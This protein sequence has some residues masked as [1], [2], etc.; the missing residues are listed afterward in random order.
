MKQRLNSRLLEPETNL[1]LRGGCTKSKLAAQYS[2]GDQGLGFSLSQEASVMFLILKS[3]TLNLCYR[4]WS[5]FYTL[6][7]E[8]SS[9]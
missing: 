3:S 5:L 6:W 1:M 8:I 7:S 9:D 2:S 4:T